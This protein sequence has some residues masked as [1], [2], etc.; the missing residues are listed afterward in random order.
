M[1][2]TAT[3]VLILRLLSALNRSVPHSTPSTSLP[4]FCL[5]P[6]PTILIHHAHHL[7]PI[8][9]LRYTSLSSSFHIHPFDSL[10]RSFFCLIF[11]PNLL[12]YL[13]FFFY[14]QSFPHLVLFH[15]T[16]ILLF[17]F[18]YYILSYYIMCVYFIC[19]FC[20]HRIFLIK[21]QDGTKCLIS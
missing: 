3:R 2:R 8:A 20:I 18:H 17:F 14:L 11:S 5:V 7:F 10:L 9:L 16:H 1:P 4:R 19:I 6:L 21:V 12:F 15:Y 13:L